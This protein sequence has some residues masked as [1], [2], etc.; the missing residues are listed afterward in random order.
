MKSDVYAILDYYNIYYEESRNS[1]ELYVLCPFHQ[2][3]SL[4]SALFN[5][6]TEMFHCFSCNEGS[7]DKYK[8]ISTL[9]G[10]SYGEAVKFLDNGFKFEK[11][12]DLERLKHKLQRSKRVENSLAKEYAVLEKKFKSKVFAEICKPGVSVDLKVKWIAIL[13]YFTGVQEVTKEVHTLIFELYTLF[14]TDIQ[15]EVKC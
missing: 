7:G 15:Q 1:A 11:S 8:F 14:L 5:T 3:T 13:S 4:G 12:Y 9:E 2:D 10:C 6:D